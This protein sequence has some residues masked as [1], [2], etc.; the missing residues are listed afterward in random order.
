[1]V[2]PERDII[3]MH[4]RSGGSTLFSGWIV[5]GEF[6]SLATT[7]HPERPQR[8][9]MRRTSLALDRPLSERSSRTNVHAAILPNDAS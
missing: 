9:M 8:P 1:M 2:K 3:K 4:C 5:K 6:S 7:R